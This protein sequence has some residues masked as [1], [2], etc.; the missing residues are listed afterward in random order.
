MK[1]GTFLIRWGRLMT[2]ARTL[3]NRLFAAISP[4][5]LLRYGIAG[6][7]IN[8]CSY[9][10]TL[11]LIALG[12][13]A[14]QAILVLTPAGVLV[15]Y[16]INRVW[17]FGGRET[18]TGAMMQLGRYVFVYAAAYFYMIAASWLLE[19]INVTSWLAALFALLS[20]AAG[21][22]AALNLWVFRSPR[23]IGGDHTGN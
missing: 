14:W 21:V 10:A 18:Q 8:L 5:A 7:V 22:Y 11:L 15:S 1:A 12:L 20:A 17:A 3:T 19:H 4:K 13:K 9:A 6:I 2:A 23:P 16:L